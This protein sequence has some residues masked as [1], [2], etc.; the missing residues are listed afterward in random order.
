M[1]CNYAIFTQ[2]DYREIVINEPINR[3]RIAKNGD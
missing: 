1:H 3:L 2:Y